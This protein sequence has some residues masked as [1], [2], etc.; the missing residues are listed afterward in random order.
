MRPE[1]LGG[2]R[3]ARMV[4]YGDVRDVGM[5]EYGNVR[6]VGMRDPEMEES[7]GWF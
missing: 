7:D 3:D 1:A 2:N 6:D 5:R 4:G